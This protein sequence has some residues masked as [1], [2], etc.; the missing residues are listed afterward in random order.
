[1]AIEAAA[2]ATVIV[3]EAEAPQVLL[4]SLFLADTIS[5]MIMAAIV[6]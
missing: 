6:S 4:K 5:L 3:P 1:M 2:A